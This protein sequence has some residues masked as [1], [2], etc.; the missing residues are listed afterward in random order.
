[1]IFPFLIIWSYGWFMGLVWVQM[2]IFLGF[3]L[4]VNQNKIIMPRKI[5]KIA[6]W[7]NKKTW[8]NFV[9]FLFIDELSEMSMFP[10]VG[11]PM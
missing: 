6:F 8:V 3:T 9:Y 2:G 1:M 11:S 7:N 5:I 10:I 4:E